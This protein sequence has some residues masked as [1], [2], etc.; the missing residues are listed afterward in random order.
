MMCAGLVACSTGKAFYDYRKSK[1][2]YGTN[3]FT[4]NVEKE[5][6]SMKAEDFVPSSQQSDYVLIKVKDYGSIVV[7]LRRDVAPKTV[8][9]FK[10]LTAEKFYD[11]TIFHRVIENFMIQGGRTV[12]ATDSNGVHT[13]KSKDAAEINGEFATNGFENNLNH[14]RGVISMA[15]RGTDSNATQE[16]V[17]AANNSAT[18][19]FFIVQKTTA[20][21]TALDGNYAAF[22]YVLA[23]MEVV[24]AIAAC[25]VLNK[26]TDFP[27]PVRDVIIESVTFVEPKE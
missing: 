5:I 10:K 14:V 11:G 22:G 2:N 23:G 20:D 6:N 7:L 8:E 24:D 13:Y 12:V 21:S 17:T 15:R 27:M 9:N 3:I 4:K 16:Q 1:T 18:S 25:E 26:G 19:E